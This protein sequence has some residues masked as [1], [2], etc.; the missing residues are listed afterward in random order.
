VVGLFWPG[1]TVTV[2]TP[3]TLICVVLG[4]FF[5]GF[6]TRYAGGCASVNLVIHMKHLY[7]LLLG[8]L[9]GGILDESRVMS[10]NKPWRFPFEVK[11][12]LNN[13][14]NYLCMGQ[15]TLEIL[16]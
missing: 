3:A 1:S 14:P 13:T 7:A 15:S 6:G 5:V 4:G 8:V 12:V 16:P 9:F 11:P 10:L 2:N